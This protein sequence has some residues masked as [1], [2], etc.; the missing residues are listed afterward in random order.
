[1]ICFLKSNDPNVVRKALDQWK[2]VLAEVRNMAEKDNLPG[3]ESYIYYKFRD[4]YWRIDEATVMRPE[5][6]VVKF[7]YKTGKWE[8]KDPNASRILRDFQRKMKEKGIP[9]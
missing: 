5:F 4:M 1:M 7:D 2:T 6:D 9:C 3:I 8:S